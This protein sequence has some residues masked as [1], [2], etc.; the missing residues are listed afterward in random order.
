[1]R[2]SLAACAVILVIAVASL[3]QSRPLDLSGLWQ[4]A[5]P[6][7]AERAL[8]TLVITSPDQLLIA[9]SPLEIVVTHPSKPGTHPEAGT[10]GY[11]ERGIVGGLPGGASTEEQWGV[12]HVGTQLMISHS[13]TRQLDDRA[14]R[15]TLAR[16]SMWRLEAPNRLI[17]E[18]SEERTGERPKVATRTYAKTQGRNAFSLER[19]IPASQRRGGETQDPY[20][21][22]APRI[23]PRAA[24]P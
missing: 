22:I 15:M 14:V 13:T 4:L 21:P 11:G 8:D 24:V 12:A 19:I 9:D 7:A 2:T 16:G 23:P 6:T 18:F 1:M 17:I 10:F 5:E 3:A 20:R